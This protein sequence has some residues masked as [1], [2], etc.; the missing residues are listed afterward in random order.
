LRLNAVI[1][2]IRAEKPFKQSS[3]SGTSLYFGSGQ[4]WVFS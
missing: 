2:E 1:S 4:K 3:E